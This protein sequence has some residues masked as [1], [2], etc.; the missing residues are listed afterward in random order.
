MGQFKDTEYNTSAL[1]LNIE[2]YL[3]ILN[4]DYLH[5]CVDEIKKL[6][7]E[8][9][10][11]AQENYVK[12]DDYENYPLEIRNKLIKFVMIHQF[13]Q[14]HEKEIPKFIFLM[15]EAINVLRSKEYFY[16]PK[17]LIDAL[18]IVDK[19]LEIASLKYA[20]SKLS[21]SSFYNQNFEYNYDSISYFVNDKSTNMFYDFMV[22]NLELI[23]SKNADY[24]GISINSSSQIV[25]GLTLSKLLK[26]NTNAH[27]NIGGNYFSRLT[28]SFANH[29]DF[30]KIYADSLL[31]EE[32]EKPVLELAEYINKKRKLEDVSNL[33]YL[34]DGKVTANKKTVPMALNDMKPLNLDGFDLKK[35]FTPEIIL[36][37]QTSRGCYWHKCSFCDHDFGL[38]YNIKSIDK[39]VEQIKIIKEKY[40]INKFE[41]IDESISPHYME[42]MAQKFL[43][44]KLEVSY[45]CDA[46]LEPEF[47]EEILKKAHDSGLKMV[48]WGLESGSKKIMDL[49]NK[50]VPFETRIDVMR[51]SANAGIF[52]FAFIFFG[53]PA[54]TKEDAMQTIELIRK[55][56]DVIHTYG[57]SV[58][59][60]GKHALIRNNP[61]KYGVK[62]E[63][64]QL[65][66][67]SPTYSF[68]AEGMTQEELSEVTDLCGEMASETY[69]NNLVF[70]LISRELIFLYLCK[71]GRE[72][73]INFR[74]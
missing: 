51:N 67:F 26:E 24:I 4:K 66:E 18:S 7:K 17:L 31:F 74:F 12:G 13:L 3:S 55:N 2:F 32:G 69:G 61:K 39:L 49:I 19:C 71:Y 22:K 16:N 9:Y 15:P 45:F 48:L 29:P 40:N 53:F 62:G 59:T 34:K 41:F 42:Q 28:E 64:K 38:C 54:E 36:P 57:R 44:E 1:D 14:Q 65:D 27:I 35:Y 5:N 21:M 47:S 63:I 73:V 70:K 10:T 8:L 6:H 33:L 46:R 37:F 43:D 20:P 68:E 50:G 11:F 52:N 30:F 60:M 72:D 58:F 25:A 23:K 56:S